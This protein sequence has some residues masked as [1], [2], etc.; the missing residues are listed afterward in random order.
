MASNAKLFFTH[1]CSADLGDLLL[2]LCVFTGP[3]GKRGRMGRRGEPGKWRLPPALFVYFSLF[4][5]GS[6]FSSFLSLA[7]TLPLFS[8]GDWISSQAGKSSDPWARPADDGPQ[9]AFLPVPRDLHRHSAN[10]GH[11]VALTLHR[12]QS[13]SLSSSS[14]SSTGLMRLSLANITTHRYCV[15]VFFLPCRPQNT[16]GGTKTVQRCNSCCTKSRHDRADV[17]QVWVIFILCVFY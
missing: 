16:H 10:L 1:L 2:C 7:P 5:E 11:V 6:S 3:P 4:L 12:C 15:V 9:L 14:C 8:L 13:F 17:V